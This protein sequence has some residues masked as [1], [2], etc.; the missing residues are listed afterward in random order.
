MLFV[1]LRTTLIL[2]FQSMVTRNLG[3]KISTRAIK[4]LS[5]EGVSD[6]FDTPSLE[7]TAEKIIAGIRF[8]DEIVKEIEKHVL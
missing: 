2:S 4:Q 3:G 1:R 6:L 8:L 5:E 7:F